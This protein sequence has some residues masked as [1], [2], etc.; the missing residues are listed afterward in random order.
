ML[1][2]LSP[3]TFLFLFLVAEL[4][5]EGKAQMVKQ[6]LCSEIEP[7]TKKYYGALEPCI[8]SC[9]HHLQAL[10]GNYAQL[11]QCFTQR[12]SLIQTSIECTQ[13]QNANAC[14]NTPGKMVPK[15]YPETLQIAIF[16]EINKMIN[17]MGLGNEA[18]G[19]LAVGKKMFSC[20]KTCMAKKSGNCEK[21]LNCGLALPP[22]NVLVQ[23]AK[24]CAMK[25]GFNTAN[26]QAICHCA[27]SAGVK[28][29]GG[30]CNKLIIT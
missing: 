30:L 26:V 17:S 16:A 21:K 28:G 23:S 7:C 9:H 15:R 6:C 5:Y 8:E 12:R 20:T 1:V 3:I 13:S 19:Y 14:S 2:K 10:G 29:L 4:F 25:S 18:K 11:K 22:D 27:A 24:Q